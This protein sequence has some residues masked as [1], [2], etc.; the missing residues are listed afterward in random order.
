[1]GHVGVGG[2][3][4]CVVVYS[5]G[6]LGIRLGV[7]SRGGDAGVTSVGEDGGGEV[8]E[9]RSN[10]TRDGELEGAKE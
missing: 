9:E 3:G 2:V 1:V 8:V 5:M 7:H 4:G 10:C 6:Y